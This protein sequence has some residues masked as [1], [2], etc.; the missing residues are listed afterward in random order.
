MCKSKNIFLLIG[1]N[2]ALLKNK[3]WWKEFLWIQVLAQQLSLYQD[4]SSAENSG[5]RLWTALYQREN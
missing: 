1:V 4:C 3:K 2:E 5:T